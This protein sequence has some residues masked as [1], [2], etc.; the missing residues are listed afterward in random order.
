MTT[1]ATILKNIA[2]EAAKSANRVVVHNEV[3]EALR[4]KG[5][6]LKNHSIW[7]IQYGCAI[8][9]G[10]HELSKVR[11]VVGRLKMAGKGLAYDFDKTREVTVTLAP[12]NEEKF[13]VTFEY[14]TKY[15]A[16][17]KCEVREEVSPARTYK[18]LVCQA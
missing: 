17:G 5:L 15:R 1:I 13:P 2:A 7:D 11:E 4:E 8:K 3:V 6:E 12:M 14:R 9:V 18:S 10:K 16:G